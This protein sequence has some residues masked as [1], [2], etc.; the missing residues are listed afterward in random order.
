[1]EGRNWEN[2]KIKK[3]SQERNKEAGREPGEQLGCHGSQRDEA[4][5]NP[6]LLETC[7][8]VK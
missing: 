2:C 8:T 3:I 5:E 1:M 6:A 4:F 7:R